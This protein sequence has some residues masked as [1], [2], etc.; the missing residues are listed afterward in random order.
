MGEHDP[1]AAWARGKRSSPFGSGHGRGARRQRTQRGADGGDGLIELSRRRAMVTSSGPD[2]SAGTTSALASSSVAPL[3]SS[4]VGE[5]E[6]RIARMDEAG[7]F[8]HQD[9]GG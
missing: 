7:E 9:A 2:A 6:A 5:R 1:A 4:K 3:I 8:A